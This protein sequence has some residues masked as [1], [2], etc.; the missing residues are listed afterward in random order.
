METQVLVFGLLFRLNLACH[1]TTIIKQQ[2][3]PYDP[4]E[5]S[6]Y[7]ELIEVHPPETCDT[8]TK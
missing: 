1:T 5:D 6:K 8:G 7:A 3:V 2:G 4:V